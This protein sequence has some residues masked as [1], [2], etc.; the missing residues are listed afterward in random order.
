VA[1]NHH[2]PGAQFNKPFFLPIASAVLLLSCD[3]QDMLFRKEVMDTLI[4]I[5]SNWQAWAVWIVF[6]S[7]LLLAMHYLM[8]ITDSNEC[9]CD[10]VD[11]IDIDDYTEF[12]IEHQYECTK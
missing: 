2:P 8:G 9:W 3:Q 11:F 7:M 1:V 6:V 10:E 4:S 5:S 12:Q